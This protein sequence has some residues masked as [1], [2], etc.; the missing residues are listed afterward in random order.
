MEGEF[1]PLY[2]VASPYTTNESLPGLRLPGSVQRSLSRLT[3]ADWVTQEMEETAIIP[4][5][6]CEMLHGGIE[7]SILPSEFYSIMGKRPS[8]SPERNDV[9]CD[10]KNSGATDRIAG[11]RSRKW[12]HRADQPC[13][14][15]D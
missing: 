9:R 3:R 13:R 12:C 10:R 1:S 11:S 4:A 8:S 2:S 14:K 5:T 6:L 15:P 7:P